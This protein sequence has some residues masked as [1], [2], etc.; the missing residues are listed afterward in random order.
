MN[1]KITDKE[2]LALLKKLTDKPKR[3][4]QIN[5]DDILNLQIALNTSKSLEEFLALV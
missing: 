1:K 5:K 3:D 4:L 2:V